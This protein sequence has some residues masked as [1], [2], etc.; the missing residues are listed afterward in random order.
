ARAVATTLSDAG[1][2]AAQAA[3][4]ST[5]FV[6]NDFLMALDKVVVHAQNAHALAS[7]DATTA[8]KASR[9][10]EL[11]GHAIRSWRRL[12]HLDENVEENNARVVSPALLAQSA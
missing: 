5:T 8:S 7:G 1:M 12:A 2:R 11:T 4:E 3:A 6:D 9:I 10:T